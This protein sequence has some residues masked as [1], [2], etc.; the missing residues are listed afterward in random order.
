LID[1]H[2]IVSESGEPSGFHR[3]ARAAYYAA[4]LQEIA[5]EA[6]RGVL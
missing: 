1:Q 3:L 2:R 6:E 5:V 4:L